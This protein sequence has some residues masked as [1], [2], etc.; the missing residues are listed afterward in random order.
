[1]VATSAAALDQ[2]ARFALEVAAPNRPLIERIVS[3]RRGRA[4]CA[5]WV[6]HWAVVPAQL[7]PG[8]AAKP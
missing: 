6:R 4:V 3:L 8:V 7:R 2:I 1:M 5:S